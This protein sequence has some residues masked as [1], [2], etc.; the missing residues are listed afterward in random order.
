MQ[1]Q[2]ISPARILVPPRGRFRDPCLRVELRIW[3]IQTSGFFPVVNVSSSFLAKIGRR[4][5]GLAERHRSGLL[6]PAARFPFAAPPAG[7]RQEALA[8]GM[9]PASAERSHAFLW[10]RQNL[11]EFGQ[12]SCDS[13]RAP[14]NRS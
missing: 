13:G 14:S 7:I 5:G 3:R 12:F 6:W 2:Q 4:R 1:A 10:Q 9:R 8:E 11:A